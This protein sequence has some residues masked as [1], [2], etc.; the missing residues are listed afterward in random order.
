M[1]V[2]ITIQS[3]YPC[4]RGPVINAFNIASRLKSKG[5]DCSILTTYFKAKKSGSSEYF[6]GVRVTRYRTQFRLMKYC[7]TLGMIK[8]LLQDCDLIHSHEYRAFQSDLGCL[9]SKIRK[10]PFVINTDGNLLCYK[11][12]IKG[13]LKRV[14]Y[15]MHN[16]F[17]LKKTVKN[18]DRVIVTSKIEYDDA[19]RFGIEKK[20]LEIIPLGIDMTLY[21]AFGKYGLGEKDIEGLDNDKLKLLFVGRLSQDRR[22]EPII[23]AIKDIS[24][25]IFYVVGA[26]LNTSGFRETSYTASLKKLVHKLGIEN[27][28]KFIGQVTGPDLVKW[29]KGA[30]IFINTSMYESFGLSILE[31]QASGLPVISTPVGIANEIIKDNYNGFIV[32]PD[33]K[34]IADRIRSLSSKDLRR[35]FGAKSKDLVRN[36][37]SW[38]IIV[39]KYLNVYE[40]LV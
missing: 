22:L 4:V 18:A 10:K 6:D 40:T 17:T 12:I 5:V 37:F 31:A 24:D 33:P 16:I 27:K 7:V 30:D 9:I 21:E 26:E 39:Q 28:V 36:N 29:Y 19:I 35:D 3:F 8:G 1:K 15:I 38:D 32:S 20:K 14:P 13:L 23:Y 34:I 11:Y 25:V 2:L